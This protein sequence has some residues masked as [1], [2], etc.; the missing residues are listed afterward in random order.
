MEVWALGIRF[1]VIPA[2]LINVLLMTDAINF[3]CGM[4]EFHHLYSATIDREFAGVGDV[5]E[6]LLMENV[7]TNVGPSRS[8][9]D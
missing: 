2:R 6:R 1:P 5:K 9:W 4:S 7:L 3:G 8:D